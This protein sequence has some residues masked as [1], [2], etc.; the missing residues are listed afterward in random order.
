ML[1]FKDMRAKN[2]NKNTNVTNWSPAGLRTSEYAGRGRSPA[3][4]AAVVYRLRSLCIPSKCWA[5]AFCKAI[6]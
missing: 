4:R 3:A 6:I 5:G 2:K 1:I